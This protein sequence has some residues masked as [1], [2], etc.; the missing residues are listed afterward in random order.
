[1]NTQANA[2][3]SQIH[4]LGHFIGGKRYQGASARSGAVFNPATGQVS[5]RVS[6]APK[7]DTD[8][9]VAAARAQQRSQQ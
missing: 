9:A 5:A 4:T 1:M 6:F 3:T 8:A 2:A 7:A